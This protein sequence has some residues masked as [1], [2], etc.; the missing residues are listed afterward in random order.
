MEGFTIMLLFKL[1]FL[2]P[3][4]HNTQDIIDYASS[5]CD[6]S[7]FPPDNLGMAISFADREAGIHLPED[8][9]YDDE[10]REIYRNAALYR[11]AQQLND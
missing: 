10:A 3:E 8:E 1:P 7:Q 11:M 9:G 2:S 6:V 4:H 5:V